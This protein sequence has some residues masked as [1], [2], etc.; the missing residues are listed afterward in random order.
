VHPEL[1][2]DALDD[3]DI[4]VT[5]ITAVA[6]NG[7]SSAKRAKEWIIPRSRNTDTNP[8][9]PKPAAVAEDQQ[10]VMVTLLADTTD[11]IAAALVVV[12]VSR[13]RRLDLE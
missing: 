11:S 3:W 6:A 7:L 4:V 10:S 1:A 13:L 2:F 8:M 5:V 9:Q 12:D